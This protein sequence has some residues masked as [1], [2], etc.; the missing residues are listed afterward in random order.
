MFGRMRT[1][2]HAASTRRSSRRRERLLP[3]PMDGK[4]AVQIALLVLAVLYTL[5]FAAALCVP[6]VAAILL[7]Q[8][9][10]GPVQAL[11]NIG[12]PLSL[13]A[14]LV[15]LGLIGL[16]ASAADFLAEP[17]E[18][19]LQDA[20]GSL[21]ELR[22][23]LQR[24]AGA[25]DELRQLGEEIDELAT[26]GEDKSGVTKVQIEPPGH[27]RAITG[28]LP[29]VISG[30][31]LAF[32]TC[33]FLLVQG[34]KLPHGLVALGPTRRT[35]RQ[36]SNMIRGV[37]AQIS[38]YLTTVTIINICLGIVVSLV[39]FGLGVPHPALWGVLAGLLNF[40][41]YVGPAVNIFI[42]LVVGITTFD[43]LGQA[44][45]VPASYLAI[46]TLEGMVLTPM[47]LGRTV[48]IGSLWV[49]LAVVF[50][51]WMWGAA[52]ALMAVPMTATLIIIW[53]SLRDKEPFG[54][55]VTTAG[56]E[57]LQ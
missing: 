46:T 45:A 8:L 56:R 3:R 34:Q 26:M 52:G 12:L 42:L 18:Q 13:S 28:S 43:N 40:A 25:L 11:N 54:S 48:N 4:L 39:M 22:R 16:I 29:I 14:A 47:I 37:Q 51:G 10:R 32:V 20:P 53:E 30:A 19:W 35:R 2:S 6:I 17:A 7:Y 1:K 44:L 31:L 57:L 38:T 50:W 21:G 36:I 33:Y 27:L 5:Y 24:T 41:P 9:L 23:E 15:L 55:G 49:F